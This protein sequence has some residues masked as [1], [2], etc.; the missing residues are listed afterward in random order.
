MLDFAHNVRDS[1]DSYDTNLGCS[2]H[3]PLHVLV[4]V[5]TAPSIDGEDDQVMGLYIFI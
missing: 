1:F 2:I 5:E 3:L 4:M